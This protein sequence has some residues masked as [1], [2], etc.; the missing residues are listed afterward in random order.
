MDYKG[1]RGVHQGCTRGAPGCRLRG[2][3]QDVVLYVV[4][5]EML[6]EEVNQPVWT[7]KSVTLMHLDRDAS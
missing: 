3:K 4:R 2:L 1:S 5:F 7:G 6:L